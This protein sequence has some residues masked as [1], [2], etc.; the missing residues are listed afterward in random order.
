MYTAAGI[1]DLR[2]ELKLKKADG[3]QEQSG[4]ALKLSRHVRS[5]ATLLQA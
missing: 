5:F 3:L 1:K 2:S 4:L